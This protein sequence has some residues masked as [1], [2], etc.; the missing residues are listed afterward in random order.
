[1]AC[2]GSWESRDFDAAAPDGDGKRLFDRVVID[3]VDELW[4]GQLHDAA[5]IYVFRCRQCAAL[6]AHWDMT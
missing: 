6:R 3:A 1:M 2:I 4:T 5:G